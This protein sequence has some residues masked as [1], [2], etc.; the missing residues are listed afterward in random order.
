M[1]KHSPELQ[2]YFDQTR[3]LNENPSLTQQEEAVLNQ[4]GKDLHI[5]NLV[6]I[7]TA[8]TKAAAKGDNL[9]TLSTI[10][11]QPVASL[12]ADDKSQTLEE[13]VAY[14]SIRPEFGN[15][16]RQMT[17]HFHFRRLSL[18]TADNPIL[19]VSFKQ[20][21]SKQ[22]PT[23]AARMFL[24]AFSHPTADDSYKSC[25][26]PDSPLLQVQALID[27]L[28]AGPLKFR[29]IIM[30]NGNTTLHRRPDSAPTLTI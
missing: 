11:A 26:L 15:I 5:P 29:S 21:L 27:Q 28:K 16:A 9:N 30:L 12:E 25:I 24:C 1:Y 17:L 4:L 23:E 18:E 6:E 14:G 8:C 20:P 2:K 7:F 19:T 3:T 13:L 22:N 10:S